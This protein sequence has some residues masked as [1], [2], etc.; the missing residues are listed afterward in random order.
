MD[1]WM[2]EK[3]KKWSYYIILILVFYLL[4]GGCKDK[5]KYVYDKVFIGKFC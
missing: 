1:R 3:M 2:N 4:N 5:R